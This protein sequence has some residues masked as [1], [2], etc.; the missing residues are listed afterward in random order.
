[1]SGIE[2]FA[3]IILPLSIAAAGAGIAYFYGRGHEDHK[4]H[5]GE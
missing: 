2:V 4:P 1:M 5:P 3:F